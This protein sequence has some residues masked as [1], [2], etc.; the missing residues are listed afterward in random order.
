[1][2]PYGKMFQSG[3]VLLV[4]MNDEPIFFVRVESVEPDIKKGW[5]QL[6][7]LIL[8]LPLK[9]ITWKLDSDQMRGQIF[10]MKGVPVNIQRVKAPDTEKESKSSNLESSSNGNVVSLFD[11]KTPK[12]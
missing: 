3:E 2:V 6:S 12:L 5:W 1:M 11:T 10:T 7:L 8:A 4:Y 9:T